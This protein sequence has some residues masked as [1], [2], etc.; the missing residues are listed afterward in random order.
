M[1][2]FE[3][4]AKEAQ[5]IVQNL[6]RDSVSSLPPKKNPKKT[7]LLRSSVYAII[8]AAVGITLLV[9]GFAQNTSSELKER[10]RGEVAIEQLGKR[11]PDVAKK[12]GMSPEE[13]RNLL[14]KDSTVEVDENDNI[15]FVEPGLSPS[16]A[17]VIDDNEKAREKARQAELTSVSAN[18]SIESVAAAIAPTEAF[19]LSSNPASSLSVYLD[20]DGNVTTG[21]SWNNSTRPEIVSAS[22]DLDGTPSSFSDNERQ[23]IIDIWKSV[24]EDYAPFNVN[25]TTKDPGV[26]ALKKIS[27]T[28]TAYGVR[29][30]ISPTNWYDPGAGGVAYVGSFSW[31][32]DTPVWVFTQQLGSSTYKSIAEAASHEVGH[33]VGLRHDGY[34]ADAYYAG[35]GNW[36]PIMGIGYYR[37]ITQF[38]KGE[39]SGAT[40]TENDLT[41][42]ANHA[43]LRT[44]DFSSSIATANAL[45]LNNGYVG[46]GY[47][48]GPAD[49]DMHQINWPG[50]DMTAR[51]TS[52][53][54]VTSTTSQPID[55]DASLTLYDSSGNR[56]AFSDPA[57]IGASTISSTLPSGTYYFGVKGVGYLDPLSTG[58]SDYASLGKYELTI[59]PSTTTPPP[60]TNNPPIAKLTPSTTS[61][62]A[63]LV[64]SFSSAGSSDPEGKALTYSW[65]FGD[66]SSSILA[67]PSYT[68]SSPGV[69]TVTL[70]VKDDVGLT[71]SASATI[72]VKSQSV[73]ITISSL[74]AQKIVS[75]K[76]KYA[77]VT[78]I[79]T[80]QNGQ[81]VSGATITGN[82][83]GLYSGT[84]S[85]IT[86]ADGKLTIKSKNIR[87]TG[88]LNFSA[89]NVVPG[90]VVIAYIWDGVQK[91]TSVV[92]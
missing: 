71:S 12:N 90:S 65:N 34:N 75:G 76:Q 4:P 44:D 62:T 43:P 51:L 74:T 69:Y 14:Q 11:L 59:S 80:D 32:T 83:S 3:I 53:A 77:L 41:I 13:L 42:I 60:P 10:V 40:N 89:T 82:W 61:G 92:L 48:E 6:A 8:F 70:T 35:H 55:L 2:K 78:L 1:E 49:S 57:S 5:I 36:A 19:N 64:V 58:Y 25:V 72:T 87:G 38:S 85:G 29:V 15:A 79:V 91:S 27:S 23:R 18:G 31:N 67:N 81:P 21:T 7:K 54:V 84:V 24:S 20:F 73:A 26:E 9:S 39:Y 88:T 68:Y 86:G 17:K 37:A 47:I 30:V 63:P 66:G 50:G 28:D 22:W 33:S 46:T 45:V 16:E 52:A 56:L